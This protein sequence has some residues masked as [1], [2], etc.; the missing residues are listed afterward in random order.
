MN[1]CKRLK[2]LHRFLFRKDIIV[3]ARKK[4]EKKMDFI[5]DTADPSFSKLYTEIIQK[6]F[7][8]AKR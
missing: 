8:W 4:D 7:E 1:F 2:I 5:H 6:S 3:V